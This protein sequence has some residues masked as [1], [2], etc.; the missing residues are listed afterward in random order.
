M[1]IRLR[2]IDGVR[3]AVCAV[4]TDAEPGD[5]YLDDADHYALAAKF[6]HDWETD[7]TYD[8]EWRA[9]ESQKLRDAETVFLALCEEGPDNE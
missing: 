1:A 8:E 3:I 2:T 9:M 5:V 7:V 4:E 6:A